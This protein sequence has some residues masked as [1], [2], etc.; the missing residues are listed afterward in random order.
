MFKNDS[1]VLEYNLTPGEVLQYKSTVTTK[2]VIQEKD[3]APE[4]IESVLEISMDQKI[5]EV[6]NG[7]AKVEVTITDGSIKRG[8]DVLPLDSVGQKLT[9]NMRR[10]GDIESTSVNFPFSQPAF[11]SKNLM[12]N[13][14]WETVN[15][16]SIPLNQNGAVKKV[17]LIYKHT[18]S[19][20]DHKNGY[21][22]AVIDIACPTVD[23]ELQDEVRQTITAEGSTY[24]AHTKG[25]LVSSK[26]HTHTEVTAPETTVSTDITVG[27]ELENALMAEGDSQ[28]LPMPDEQ[29]I[30]GT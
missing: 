21:D 16:I 19:R 27:V 18:L 15:P 2:Q 25:R 11:P 22:V 7:V 30:I 23:M 4:V 14:S 1:I 12:P 28:T 6:N 5:V 10:N 29:F 17:N 8:S 20:L 24:F 26:V 13:D 3:E 9:M